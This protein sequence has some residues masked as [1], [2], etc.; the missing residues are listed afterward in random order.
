MFC[1][2]F[3][4]LISKIRGRNGPG[5][6]IMRDMDVGPDKTEFIWLLNTTLEVEFC[7]H[8]SILQCGIKVLRFLS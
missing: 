8:I 3:S 5:A 6:F 1:I 4:S 7:L 2:V